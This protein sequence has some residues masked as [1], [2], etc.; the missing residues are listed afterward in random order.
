G[1]DEKRRRRHLHLPR[2]RDAGLIRH[3][4]FHPRVR[5]LP[6]ELLHRADER[7]GLASIDARRRM[8]RECRCR[9]SNRKNPAPQEPRE[10]RETHRTFSFDC[11]LGMCELRSGRHSTSAISMSRESTRFH[12]LV[13]FH[14]PSQLLGSVIVYSICI[15]F[16]PSTSRTRS[17]M[18]S[19]SLAGMPESI[20]WWWSTNPMVSIPTPS[21]SNRPMESPLNVRTI[22]SGSV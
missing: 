8:M 15:F 17:T 12:C 13:T 5:V 11:V 22:R 19:A 4:D 21:P 18:W 10:P 14:S 9:D 2:G 1:A 3:V 16:P 7:D 6:A 20:Q